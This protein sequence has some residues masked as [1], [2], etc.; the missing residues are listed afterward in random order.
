MAT[1]T[2]AEKYLSSV[3][4]ARTNGGVAPIKKEFLLTSEQKVSENRC[5]DQ[6]VVTFAEETFYEALFLFCSAQVFSDSN[7]C[8]GK[9]RV[10]SRKRQRGIN[11]ERGREMAKVTIL[12]CFRWW[13][14]SFS[15]F[16]DYCFGIC[17]CCGQVN[18][19]LNCN[20]TSLGAKKFCET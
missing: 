4:E 5:D 17:K 20:Y 8:E 11:R 10:R 18:F 1:D 14:N 12:I 2:I 15:I 16:F 13:F 9:N 7:E 6:G 19:I 3:K